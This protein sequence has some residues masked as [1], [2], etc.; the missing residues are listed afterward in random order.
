MRLVIF[1]V[2]LVAIGVLGVTTWRRSG[3]SAGLA[4]L[5]FLPLFIVELGF[6]GVATMAVLALL[7]GA[8]VLAVG[9]VS[10]QRR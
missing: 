10:R 8:A 9:E 3:R 6:Y 4:M 2:A 7:G 1:A 5:V